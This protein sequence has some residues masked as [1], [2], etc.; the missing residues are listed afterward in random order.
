MISYNGG[1]YDGNCTN[2]VNHA[3]LLTGFGG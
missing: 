1:I 2:I 3:M